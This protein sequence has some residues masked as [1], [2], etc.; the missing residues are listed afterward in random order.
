MWDVQH[1]TT[2][3]METSAVE[4]GHSEMCYK[5]FRQSCSPGLR[6]HTASR[7]LHCTS[8]YTETLL[9]CHAM[10]Y[11]FVDSRLMA[12]G[13]NHCGGFFPFFWCYGLFFQR[14]TV[15]CW[16]V[17]SGISSDHHVRMGKEQRSSSLF[18][19]EPMTKPE[20]LACIQLSEAS[21]EIR[22]FLI[23]RFWEVI[24]CEHIM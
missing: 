8:S 17:S 19:W 12:F 11:I 21:L 4:M 22:R 16:D 3:Q 2:V 6:P 18:A 1:H 14:N 20:D 23:L 9:C 7:W 15:W 5:F 10:V 13:S 24:F